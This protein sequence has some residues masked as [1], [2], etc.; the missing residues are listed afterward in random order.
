MRARAI[1]EG[2]VGL[3]ILIGVG[4][5]GGLVLW[6]RG[7]NPGSRNYVIL[8]QFDNT[9]GM[10]IGT[11][12]RYRGVP[13]GRV[14]AIQPSSNQVEIRAEIT[15]ATLRIPRDVVIEANQSGFIGET[16]IDITPLSTLSESQQAINPVAADC[17]SAVI[18]CNGDTL[19]GVVGVSY[20]S[21]LKSA[22]KLAT[23][24]ADPA[25]IESIKAT[26]AN[27]VIL[28]EKVSTLTD[29][30]T[31][32]TLTAQAEVQPLAASARQA[33]DNAAEAAREIQLTATDVRS[34]IGANQANVTGTLVNINRSSDRLLSLLNTVGTAV[35]DGEFMANLELLSANA[36]EASANLRVA[37]ADVRAITGTLNTPTNL[38]LIQQTLESARAVFQGAQ[39]LLSDVDELTGDP[40]LRNNLR[41]LINGLS[42]LLSSTQNLEQQMELAQVL[43]QLNALSTP[44]TVTIPSRSS[45]TPVTLSYSSLQSQLEALA[46]EEPSP[47]D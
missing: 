10:Q 14:L 5:F 18:L 15:D 6:L 36:A 43:T 42:N 3:L 7:I 26:L 45:S 33:T 11:I 2:S 47:S 13:V 37:S 16:T 1:R 4:L 21:L 35:D 24:F 27:A 9:M 29:E 39:K 28:T 19:P 40:V 32:L 8:L 23:L 31:E 25:I 17:D 30:L 44:L 12:V 20:E 38:L 34:L 22:D 46:A 41:N